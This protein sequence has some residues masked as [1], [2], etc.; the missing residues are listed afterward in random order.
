MSSILALK[1]RF[2]LCPS[3]FRPLHLPILPSK[4]VPSA[5]L[6]RFSFH[7]SSHGPYLLLGEQDL[8]PFVST[9][10]TTPFC[11]H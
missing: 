9:F 6:V 10:L 1:E 4:T 3:N 5:F 2:L 8:G 7:E 11:T